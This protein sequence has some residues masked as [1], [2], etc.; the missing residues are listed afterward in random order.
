MPPPSA[1]PEPADDPNA[2]HDVD[3]SA[4]AHEL[5]TTRLA[6]RATSMRHLCGIYA[7]HNFSKLDGKP[8]HI[9]DRDN[10]KACH[11]CGIYAASMRHIASWMDG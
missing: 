2:A 3:V 8:Y 1:S 11:E 7:A 10:N 5:C 9:E 6:A 4:G